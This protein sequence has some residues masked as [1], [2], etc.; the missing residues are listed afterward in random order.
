[1]DIYSE[2]KS[3]H[4]L[5]KVK[6]EIDALSSL[7]LDDIIKQ[8][9]AAGEKNLLVDCTEL[10]YIS[11]A[12]LGVFMSYIKDLEVNERKMILFGLSD[13]VFSTFEI[14][15]LHHII[16]LVKTEEEALAQC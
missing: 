1:M 5:L 3:N 10:F 8:S 4:I 12:G 14:L 11:S 16:Q 13:S 2:K 15:G 7:D 6:G 9:F